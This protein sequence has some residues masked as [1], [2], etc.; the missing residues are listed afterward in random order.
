M[1]SR[2]GTGNSLSFFYG[3]RLFL[4][5]L[6]IRTGNIIILYTRTKEGSAPQPKHHPKIYKTLDKPYF[7]LHTSFKGTV[8]LNFCFTFFS[9]IT[10]PE[11]PENN[12]RVISNFLRKFAEIFASQGAPPVSTTPVA[13][14]PPIPLVLLTPV[15][16]WPP[17]STIPAENLPPL[18]TPPGAN[19]HRYQR[20]RWQIMGTSIRLQTP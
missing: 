17:V 15:A 9:W 20:Y 10:F 4:S 2:L 18:L 1:T 19:C 16:N 6:V 13:N 7:S 12:I 14:L 5:L 8:S 11:A 3:V